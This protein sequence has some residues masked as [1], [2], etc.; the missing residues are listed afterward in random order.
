MKKKI[1]VLF[2]LLASG[3]MVLPVQSSAATGENTPSA[4]LA[5]VGNPIQIR[6][7]RRHHRRY[8]RVYRYRRYRYHRSYRRH[9]R[10]TM[11]HHY[12]R[13]SRRYRVRY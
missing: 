10:H 2:L 1:I 4:S 7:R 13:H 11:R 5:T 8:Y 9:Y 6:Y 12:R 3:V